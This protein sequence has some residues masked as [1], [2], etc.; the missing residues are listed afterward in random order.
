MRGM[1]ITRTQQAF[2]TPFDN[3]MNGFIASDTQTAI[4]EAKNTGGVQRFSINFLHNST[5]GNGQRMGFSNLLPNTPVII[6]KGSLLKE[7]TFSN[8]RANA[9]ARFDIYRRPI[10]LTTNVPGVTA[11]LLQQWTLTNTLAAVLSNM[12]HDFTGGQELLII[13]NSTGVNP[14][15]VSMICFFQAT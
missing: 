11:T 12:N 7:I 15:D 10:P 3:S 1:N 9:D 14:A 6:P 2:Q 4:E 8:D 5:L 13:F